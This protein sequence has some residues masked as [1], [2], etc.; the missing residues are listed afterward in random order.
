MIDFKVEILNRHS[1]THWSCMDYFYDGWMDALFG[2]QTL[3]TAMTKMG[4][5]KILFNITPTVFARKKKGM[6]T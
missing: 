5:A 3:F 6:Y 1:L 4:R 2:A